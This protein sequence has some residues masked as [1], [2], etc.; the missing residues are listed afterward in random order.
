MCHRA[1]SEWEWMMFKSGLIN[2]CGNFISYL[3]FNFNYEIAYNR[4][5]V[6]NFRR[7]LTSTCLK[8]CFNMQPTDESC[9]EIN[10]QFIFARDLKPSEERRL[11]KSEGKTRDN[12]PYSR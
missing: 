10:L 3:F 6:N 4:E 8:G 5:A 9:G 1:P 7:Y 12:H 2:G 11:R